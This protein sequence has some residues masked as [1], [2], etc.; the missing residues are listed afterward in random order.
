MKTAS[1][2]F[3]EVIK[4][5]RILEAE[6]IENQLKLI[7]KWIEGIMMGYYSDVIQSMRNVLKIYR[8]K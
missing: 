6:I 1:E 3:N 5:R 8:E 4:E 7:H 2:Y